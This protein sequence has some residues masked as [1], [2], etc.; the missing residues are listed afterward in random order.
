MP[1]SKN[2][3]N[4]NNSTMPVLKLCFTPS[5]EIRRLAALDAPPQYDPLEQLAR[6]LFAIAAAPGGAPRRDV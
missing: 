6:R 3:N 2:K 5:G 1:F 4:N